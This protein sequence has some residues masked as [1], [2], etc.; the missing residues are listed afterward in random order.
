MITEFRLI[1]LSDAQQIALYETNIILMCY[2][3]GVLN[4]FG[5]QVRR[6]INRIVDVK[7]RA[8]NRRIQLVSKA[9]RQTTSK[10]SS[11]KKYRLSA[12]EAI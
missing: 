8:E 9:M 5:Q 4:G 1:E 3:S 2:L 12:S 7:S 10:L 11:R 6:V